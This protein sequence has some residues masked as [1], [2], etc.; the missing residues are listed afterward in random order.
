MPDICFNCFVYYYFL[1]ITELRSHFSIFST[2]RVM[3][4]S[5]SWFVF[6][7][8]VDDK[9]KRPTRKRQAP[10]DFLGK[11][12]DRKIFMGKYVM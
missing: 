12:P 2:E 3:T 5:S 6:N 9:P 7:R 11:G 4:V 1:F 8:T 10:E